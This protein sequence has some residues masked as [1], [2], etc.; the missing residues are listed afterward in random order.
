MFSYITHV[1]KTNRTICSDRKNMDFSVYRVLKT[2][3]QFSVYMIV[4]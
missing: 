4:C 3:I 1:V 2:T